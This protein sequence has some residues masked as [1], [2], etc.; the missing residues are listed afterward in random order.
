MRP[1]YN[2]SI[3][4]SYKYISWLTKLYPFVKLVIQIRPR[5]MSFDDQIERVKNGK[6]EVNVS[7]QFRINELWRVFTNTRTI[8]S[9]VCK[10][11]IVKLLN[12]PSWKP[13]TFHHLQHT[14]SF[15]VSSL[16]PLWTTLGGWVVAMS[17][18]DCDCEGSLT[19]F[20]K[21]LSW[22]TA[23]IFPLQLTLV[24]QSQNA[25]FWFH[26][27]PNCKDNQPKFVNRMNQGTLKYLYFV[28]F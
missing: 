22:T 17:I 2:E 10:I 13:K 18:A 28:I 24:A 19:K 9:P 21:S 6:P 27:R 25:S 11:W 12:K 20:S 3:N 26:K 8:P 23:C 14:T 5:V 1:P 16:C 4:F 7:A 15:P